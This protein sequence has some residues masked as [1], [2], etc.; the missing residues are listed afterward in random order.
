MIPA[1]I[2]TID[3]RH[4][5]DVL[6]IENESFTTTRWSES[7]FTAALRRSNVV[8]E[9]ALVNGYVV[10][11]QVYELYSDRIDL[12]NIAVAP[13]WRRRGVGRLFINRLKARLNG[14]IERPA[15]FIDV[16][17]SS[18]NTQLFLKACGLLCVRILR[19]HC[20][21]PTEDAY[22]F[23]YILGFNQGRDAA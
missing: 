14:A 7:D 10:G 5:D 22:R 16:R 23:T 18:V 20:E 8:G 17:E 21:L 19:N 4:I 6:E 12:A 2:Q 13:A 15:L 11:Y 1:F 3:S 9:V